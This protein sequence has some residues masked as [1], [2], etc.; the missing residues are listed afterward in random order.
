M[1]CT[2]EEA[3]GQRKPANQVTTLLLTL[4]RSASD[5]LSVCI[6]LQFLRILLAPEIAAAAKLAVGLFTFK[7]RS[8][9]SLILVNLE[10][11]RIVFP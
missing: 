6:L 11:H 10:R 8:N 9:C 2:N 4:T 1:P 3:R 5:P 7:W